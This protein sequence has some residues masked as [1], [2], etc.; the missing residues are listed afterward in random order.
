MFLPFD[1]HLLGAGGTRQS[2][3]LLIA[4][5][6]AHKSAAQVALLLFLFAL[7][8]F[9]LEQVIGLGRYFDAAD[10]DVWE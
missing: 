5:K 1:L 8:S 4:A 6:L 3:E 2:D 7:G 9:Y 10:I